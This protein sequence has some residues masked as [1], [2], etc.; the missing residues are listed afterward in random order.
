M[1][2]AD[3]RQCLSGGQRG[4]STASD[5]KGVD[6]KEK[7]SEKEYDRNEVFN[8]PRVLESYVAMVQTPNSS[9]GALRIGVGDALT[10]HQK[11]SS[12]PLPNTKKTAVQRIHR[13]NPTSHCGWKRGDTVGPST[14]TRRLW[15][16]QVYN[17]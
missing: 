16:V 3:V 9:E 5:E 15:P 17:Y 10:R 6:A 2:A 7:V 8:G 4:T 13:P 12:G 14:Q 11:D 1:R